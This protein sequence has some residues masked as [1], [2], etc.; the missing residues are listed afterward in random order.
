[1]ALCK[2][3]I[4]EQLADYVDGVLSPALVAELEAHLKICPPCVAYLRTYEKTCEL[5]GRAGAVE[6]PAEM[7][8]ILSAF[9]REKL[10][11]EKS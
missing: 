8:A 10:S 4:E 7:K 1:M 2:A 9:I 5:V 11:A 3:F 6:M